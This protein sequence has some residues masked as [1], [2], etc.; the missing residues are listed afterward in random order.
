MPESLNAGE[1]TLKA[2]LVRGLAG[3]SI[4]YRECLRQVSARLR[5]F[6][7]RRLA[8]SPNDVEDLLQEIL[9]AVHTQRHTYDA[10]QL[11]T[12]WLYGIARYKLI[13]HY[14]RHARSDALNEPLDDER[15]LLAVESNDPG[16]ARRD[17]FA[18]LDALPPNQRLPI[19]HTKIEG[20]SVAETARLTGM[21]ESAV[22]VGVHRGLKALCAR[23]GDKQ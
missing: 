15:E 23:F 21:S 5:G 19:L 8:A 1:E 16:D 20:L 14:R 2:L 17:V 11:L 7:R 3:D 12:P 13:D 6:L 10:T 9:L 18:M 4:A 22:K